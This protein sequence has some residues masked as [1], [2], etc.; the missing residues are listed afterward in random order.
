[1]L[2]FL[3]IVIIVINMLL[4]FVSIDNLNQLN[5]YFKQYKSLINEL[6]KDIEK[7]IELERK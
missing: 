4:I 2:E 3:C 5:K 7:L 1:M 6:K